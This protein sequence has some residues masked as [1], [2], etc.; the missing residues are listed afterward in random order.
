MHAVLYSVVS[1]FEQ[2]QWM[3]LDFIEK[4]CHDDFNSTQIDGLLKVKGLFSKCKAY[5]CLD[6]G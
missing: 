3:A 2:P 1:G 6:L 4:H 5:D